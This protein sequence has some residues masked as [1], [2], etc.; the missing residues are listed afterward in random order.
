MNTLIAIA[1]GGAI[2]SLSRHGLTV[3]CEHLLGPAFPY[4]IFLANILGSF[5][6]GVLFVLLVERGMA[7]EVI[8]QLLMVGFLGAF[9]TF[10]TFSLQAIGMLQDGRL[11]TATSYILGSVVLSILAAWVGLTVTRQLAL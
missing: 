5:A 3:L 7:S 10:S 2:G 4:G 6:I 9:T 1:L 11:L 8:R